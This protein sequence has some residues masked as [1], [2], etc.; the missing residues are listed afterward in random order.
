MTAPDPRLHGTN[1]RPDRRTRLGAAASKSR[2]PDNE[3]NLNSI[4]KDWQEPFGDRGQ[5]IVYIGQNLPKDAMIA[6]L[7]RCLVTDEEMVRGPEAWHQLPNPF[8]EWHTQAQA[9]RA[10]ATFPQ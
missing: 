7:D 6:E 9:A 3:E 10:Q 1:P 2:W 4:M 8:P 5:Q